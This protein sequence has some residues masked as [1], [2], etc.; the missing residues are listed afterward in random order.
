MITKKYHC[1]F[2]GVYAFFYTKRSRTKNYFIVKS[3]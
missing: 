1:H 3:E 2:Y